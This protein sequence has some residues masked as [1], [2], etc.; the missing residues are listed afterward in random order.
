MSPIPAK[1]PPYQAVA[2]VL[3]EEILSGLLA[4]GSPLPTG[5][6]IAVRFG[7]VRTT[8]VRAVRL[9]IAEGLVVSK[10][11]ARSYV[12]ELPSIIR[13]TRDWYSRPGT[14][15]PWRA[16]MAAI[17]RI[18]SW[19]H[20]SSVEDAAPAVAERLRIASGDGVMHTAYLYLADG[21]PAYLADSWEP[22][23][24]TSGTAV[25]FP[26]RGEYAGAGVRDRMAAIG[27]APDRYREE[28]R[29]RILTAAQGERLG[30][31]P[32]I[33]VDVIHRTY[34]EGELPLE[35]ATLVL[36]PHVVAVYEGPVA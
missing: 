14:G 24:I 17:G 16:T 10:P 23:A 6:E 35:T 18:G 36:A 7:M 34:F 32:G 19:V 8:A 27:H 11:G 5:D 31:H 21:E 29:P 15:S 20:S 13:L 25:R 33:V 28:H 9:L 1:P 4:P 12:R 2:D 3:R 26:E 22:L 30:L